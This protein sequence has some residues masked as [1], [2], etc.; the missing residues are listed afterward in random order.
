MRYVTVALFL[1]V[2]NLQAVVTPLNNP[3]IE[4][5]LAIARSPAERARFHG[6]Y[7]IFFNG[8]VLDDYFQLERV[9]LTTEFRRVE[10][11]GEQYEAARMI[12]GVM[13][14]HK[15]LPPWVD[16]VSIAAH[17]KFLPTMHYITTG[18]TL[19][20]VLKGGPVAVSVRR[21]GIT[22]N[23]GEY[24]G[25][26]LIE[27]VTEADF[28]ASALRDRAYQVLVLWNGRSIGETRVDFGNLQ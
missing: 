18:P 23:S 22:G 21:T 19:D 17:V 26:A 14:V 15:V 20:I 10:L 25:S 1:S 13:D 4:R 28:S 6:S 12:I 27:S 5:A 16:R 2:M 7:V 9:E 8:P 3:E 24:G 11:L